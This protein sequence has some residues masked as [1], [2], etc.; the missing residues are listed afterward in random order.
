MQDNQ[1]IEAM[2]KHDEENKFSVT[3]TTKG[4]APFIM[5]DAEEPKSLCRD[6][7]HRID[8][9]ILSLVNRM[10]MR[11]GDKAKAD[12]DFSCSIFEGEENENSN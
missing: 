1:I 12:T 11:R 6:C 4:L 8:C 10:T 5:K 2:N 9:P 3:E 7:I